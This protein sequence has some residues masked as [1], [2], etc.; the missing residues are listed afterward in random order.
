MGIRVTRAGASECSSGTTLAE[1]AGIRNEFGSVQ[2]RFSAERGTGDSIYTVRI[3]PDTF[4]KL[5]S[6]M[7]RANPESARKAFGAALQEEMPEPEAPDDGFLR[8]VA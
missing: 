4:E 8:P 1:N 2:I 3:R 6:A 7:W 5:A